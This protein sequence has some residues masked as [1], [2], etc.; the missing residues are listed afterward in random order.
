VLA[1]HP[2]QPFAV[3]VHVV[4]MQ[5]PL[6]PVWYNRPEPHVFVLAPEQIESI[7]PGLP[8]PEQQVFGLRLAMAVEAH[9]FAVE[10]GRT[11]TEFSG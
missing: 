3:A 9:D 1:R 11:A 7:K 10:H 6:A 4:T 5:E 8:T 2:E